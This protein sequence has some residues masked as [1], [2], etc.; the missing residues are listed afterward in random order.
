MT[1]CVFT[2]L[3]AA[4]IAAL[5]APYLFAQLPTADLSRLEPRSAR[6]GET[7]EITLHGSNLEELTELRFTNPGI[8]AKPV[9]LPADEFFP[10]PH[11]VGSRFV[12]KVAADVPP[13]IYDAR[14]VGYFG[15]STARPFVVAAADSKEV[16]EPGNN[17]MPGNAMSVEIN[18]VV[19]G[20]VASRGIDW[21]RFTAKAG[22]RVLVELIAERIDSR[23]DGQLTVYD[24]AGREV[25]RN[26]D[27]FGRDSFLEV[28]AQQ[29]GKFLLAVS[30][31]LYRGGGDHFYRLSI[32]DRPHI[33]F[34]YPPAGE[35]GSTNLYTL[36][37]RNLPGGVL[38]KSSRI[39]GHVLEKH[40]VEIAL[41]KVASTPPGFHPGQPRQGLLPGFDYTFK[42]ANSVR[43]G[44][45][46]APV[47]LETAN[48][49]VQQISVPSEVAG[50][51]DEANDEDVFRFTTQK[52]QTYWV[53]AIADR[54][55]SKVDPWLI[56]HQVA[57]SED[58]VETLIQVA[59]NDDMPGFFSIDGKDTINADT[60]DAA[61]SFK[62]VHDGEYQ[63]TI[64]NQFGSGGIADL[65]R[66]AIR[67]ATPDFQLIATAEKTLPTNRTGYSV[68]PLLR[69]GARWGIRVLCPRQD[70]FAGDI[71]ISAQEL[72]PGV[73]ATP[74][75]LSGMTDRGILV[76]SAS[77]DAKSWS[78]E[79]RIVGKASVSTAAGDHE[80]V[81]D[82]RFASLVWG[83]IFADSIRVRSRLTE[84]IPLSLNQHEKAPVSIDVVE[85]KE[86]TVEVGQK[87]EI[88]VKV[89]DISTRVG[90]L[91][92]EPQG[93]FG[94]L[95]NPPQVNIA[96]KD[97]DGTLTINFARN[98]NFKV[99]PGRYQ[100]TLQG[101][102]VAK[103]R[104][105][106]PASVRT[107]AEQ[108]RIE[109]L[110]TE[111][112]AAAVRAMSTVDEARKTLDV[113]MQNLASAADD[114]A[115]ARLRPVAD[116]AKAT[117]DAAEVAARQ[118][119]EKVTAVEKA[120]TTVVSVAKAAAAKAVEKNTKFAAWSDL[121]TVVVTEP[122]ITREQPEPWPPSVLARLLRQAPSRE[123]VKPSSAGGR[124]YTSSE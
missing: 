66:L 115:K 120:K 87:L 88:P 122:A 61:V 48:D 111:I 81:R 38:D 28:Q 59:D 77:A 13:G 100:F 36:Y 123:L 53:E 64:A 18:S 90:N 58:G 82:A 16:T 76:V 92:I 96:E 99:E 51:F 84:R 41:P 106:Y 121:I 4:L 2:R 79:I 104:H 39:R 112:S 86:W 118:A 97:S 27:T 73:T 32:S 43:I 85:D 33:D 69:Q 93:L 37:G 11:T 68:T 10:R 47:V 105:N 44:F 6:A 7:V 114:D 60:I 116:N 95:R 42:E 30:D 94:I 24:S 22:Q 103:Y 63:V 110:A 5:G 26:R 109:K 117:L 21:F 23:L 113:A 29:D 62:S 119:A 89:T 40:Q 107:A 25:D 45:A 70:G 46:T 34:V 65:Y 108:Q 56:V 14:A 35:P 71:V 3:I 12:V 75:T 72:P 67:A 31:I 80:L 17:T 74:L 9:M 52:D 19:T 54:M 101:T 15:L 83:H 20:A 57:K 98:G 1:H 49:A 50:R 124:L 55:Q 91:T 78:G 8:T 102:G